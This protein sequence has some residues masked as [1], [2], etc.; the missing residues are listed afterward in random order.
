MSENDERR[1]TTRDEMTDFLLYTAPGGQVK[2]ECIL[3]DETIWLTQRRIS[4]L[5]GV[6]VPAISKHLKNI[7]EGGEL[8]EEVVVS[9]L[10]TVASHNVPLAGT[11]L[12]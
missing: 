9:I 11:V 10:E 7:F 4:E 3:H 6:G 8:R 12:S 1:L 2:V 5:F